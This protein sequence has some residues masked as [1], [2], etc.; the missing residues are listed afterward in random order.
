MVVD[1]IIILIILGFVF[2]GIK[3]GLIS[4]IIDI[5]SVVIALVLALILCRPIT[6]V[7]INN[8]NFDENLKETIVE[9]IPLNDVNF[10]VD[11]NSNLPKPVVEYINGITKN[12]GSSKDEAIEV[13]SKELTNGIITVIVFIAIFI[14]VRIIFAIIKIVSKLIDKIPGLNE[15][16]KIGGGICGAIEGII[17][18]YAIFAVISMISPILADTN[19]LQYVYKSNI[20]AIMYN[21]NFILKSI[22]KM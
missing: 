13:I 8:T 11:E 9:N 15:V 10:R 22:Y 2:I 6:N 18:V 20:G 21:H 12:V 17:I 4:C 16:N 5:C 3:K 7:V 14:I 1:I 19:I